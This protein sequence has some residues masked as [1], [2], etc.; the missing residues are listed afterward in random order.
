MGSA[1]VA[2]TSSAGLDALLWAAVFAAGTVLPSQA[3]RHWPALLA[4]LVILALAA[5]RTGSRTLFLPLLLGAAVAF[6]HRLADPFPALLSQWKDHGFQ[7]GITPIEIE[8]WVLDTE[9]LPEAR[10]ALVLRLR[11]FE[12][13][14]RPPLRGEPTGKILI[15]LT[16]PT[17]PDPGVALPR[18]GDLVEMSVRVGPPRTFRNPGAFDYS[19]YLEARGIDLLG[20]SKS[21]RLIRSVPGAGDF[22][23]ALPSRIRGRMVSSLRRAAGY[24][25]DATVSFLAALLVGDRDD[26]PPEFED[27]LIRAGVYHIVALSGFNVAL[28]V[29]LASALLRLAPLSP[30][31]RRALL[32]ACVL[33]YWGIARPSGSIARAALMSL[34]CLGGAWLGRRVRGTGAIASASVLILGAKPAWCLDPGFQLSFAATLGLLFLSPRSGGGVFPLP[35]PAG[36]GRHRILAGRVATWFIGSLGVSGAAFLSTALISARHFQALTPVAL[37]ANLFAVPISA[38]LLVVGLLACALEP[39]VHSS[40]SLLLDLARM[41]VGALDWMTATVAAPAWCS[42]FVLPPPV[43]IVLLGQSAVLLAGFGRPRLRRASFLFLAFALLF[44]AGAGRA[45]EATGR[46]DVVALDVGQGDAL[47]VRFPGGP[48]ML[49]DAGGF[50]R[51]RFDVG[52]KVVAPALRALGLLK[53]DILAITHAHRDHLGGAAAILRS[54]SPGALWLGRM[55]DDDPAILDL[56][57]E[58]A[59]RGIAVVFPRRGA[60]IILGGTRVEVLNPGRGVDGRGPA[61][62]DDSLVLRLLFGGRGVLLTGDLEGRLETVLVGEGRNLQADLLKV[63]HHGS[64]TSTTA[65][66]LRQVRPRAGVISVGST[67]PWGHPDAEVLGRLRDAG[68]R[69]YRTDLDGA[70]RF[71]TDGASS[72]QAIP[73]AEDAVED[74]EA[75]REAAGSAE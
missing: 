49:V 68:V 40:A 18:P 41:L 72:W 20:S 12:I 52:S 36:R 67:N 13:P 66:F 2:P 47:L 34:L 29:G 24:D 25:N 44:I 56:E 5:G 27:R 59:A 9:N 19:S 73:L 23:A 31:T 39:F 53:I 21:P 15:R 45:P 22:L 51:S 70:V 46:L 37:V 16:A 65:G 64:R 3:P 38:L 8:G 60:S 6:A 28:I 63:G 26:L 32:A 50:A 69:I 42:F 17:P 58:A 57:R 74:R 11:R 30:R 4:P 43:W 7:A 1:R 75:I 61:K 14:G 71:T 62:N 54:F 33:V 55:P 48:V 10:T 35:S